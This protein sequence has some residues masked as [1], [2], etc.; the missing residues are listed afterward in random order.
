[1][2]RSVIEVVAEENE[3]VSSVVETTKSYIHKV[4]NKVTVEVKEVREFVKSIAAD[5]SD[6]CDVVKLGIA[7]AAAGGGCFHTE[8][9]RQIRQQSI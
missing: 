1:M 4:V 2:A 7:G 6:I 3:K 8:H 9:R 5:H